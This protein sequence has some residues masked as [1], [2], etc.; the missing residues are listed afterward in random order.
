MGEQ[1]G[2]LQVGAVVNGLRVVSVGPRYWARLRGLP[3]FALAIWPRNTAW[4]ILK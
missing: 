3:A 2:A 4:Q 1:G